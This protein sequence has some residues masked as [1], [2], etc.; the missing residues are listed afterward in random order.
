MVVTTLV[1]G[2]DPVYECSIKLY[3]VGVLN[4]AFM[5]WVVVRTIVLAIVC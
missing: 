3:V 2:F 5:S 1:E 4:V